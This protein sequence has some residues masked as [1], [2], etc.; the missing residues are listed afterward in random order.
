M[1][2]K[3]YIVTILCAFLLIA[4]SSEESPL[5][6][7][8]RTAIE[9]NAAIDK[10]NTRS[11]FEGS[12]FVAGDEFMLY[13]DMPS[14]GATS[15]SYRFNESAWSGTP[16][17]YW[18]DLNIWN[19]DGT[20][21]ASTPVAFTAVL[22]NGGTLTNF[23][24]FAIVTA[25]TTDKTF[26][27]SDLLVA[28][29]DAA[30][31]TPLK[32]T[33]N[34]V[35]AR[36]RIELT[37][38]TTDESKPVILGDKTKLK[39]KALTGNTIDFDPVITKK[40]TVT[41]TGCEVDVTLYRTAVSG[42]KYTYEIILPAQSLREETSVLTISGNANEKVY[43]YP[44]SNA[45]ITSGGTGN[46][47]LQQGYTTT[48]ALS[49]AK[50][51]LK[52]DEVTIR[53]WVEKTANGTATPDDYPIIEIGGGEDGETPPPPDPK[54]DYAG[55]TIKLTKDISLDDLKKELNIPLGT[56]EAPFRGTFDGQ[57]YTILNV[58]INEE[59]DFLG[60]FGYADGATIKDLNV[61][62][63]GIVNRSKNSS[64]ATGG[65][66]G[67]VNNTS[68]LNCHTS[69]SNKVEAAYDN[70]GGLVGYVNGH[71]RIE[72]CSSNTTVTAGH[73]YA[74]GLVG[75]AKKGARIV[76][77]FSEKVGAVK[78][79]NYYAG[80][81]VGASYDVDVEYCYSWSDA[82]ARRYAGGLIGRFESAAGT[83][84]LT[85]CY[86]AGKEVSGGSN[87][88]GMV[89]FIEIRPNHPDKCYWNSRL[90]AGFIG[91]YQGGENSSFTL[92]TTL[93]AMNNVLNALNNDKGDGG[94]WELTRT[95]YEGYVLPTLI[96]NK[97]EAEPNKGE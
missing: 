42:R 60:I 27:K 55:K 91:L 93:A 87:Q 16:G 65:L 92:T 78:A 83:N 70:A 22:T 59:Q 10:Q 11:N 51:E 62:G 31:L 52:I 96:S 61:T 46:D 85:N 5:P 32:L 68:I 35:F 24:S 44:L 7:G 53:K 12:G 18:D 58:N 71:S 73:D 9:V 33:F 17:L 95:N 14:S 54:E 45:S 23:S 76:Y 30:P 29:T 8:S 48:I 56:K 50:T 34:H 74:G 86:A 66:A 80:G 1:V 75:I 81:L 89:S 19:P 82:R 77:S 64:T 20:I 97:G 57:G 63:T 6:I 36:L 39:V 3:K 67:Y 69:Y 90:G 79:E 37:D 40:T 13:E 49:I 47:L 43:T 94:E 72:G 4:C 21:K 2:Y 28:Y 88:A 41:A 38:K 84:K 25:P 15:S 26:L